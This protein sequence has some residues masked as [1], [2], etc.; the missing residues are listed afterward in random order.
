M[1][2]LSPH[3]EG[4]LLPVR[5]QPG[6]RENR[7]RGEQAG[8]LKVAVTQPPERGRANQAVIE[9]LAAALG[10]KRGQIAL[11]AGEASRQKTF[12]I[13]GLAIDDLR[14]RLQALLAE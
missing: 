4:V 9:V 13:R 7:V 5:A 14:Q 8:A 1:I 6:G 2:A 3:R 10:V 12:L 11:A